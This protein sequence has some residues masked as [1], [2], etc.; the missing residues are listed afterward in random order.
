MKTQDVVMS[1]GTVL[2]CRVVPPYALGAVYKSVPEPKFP[3]IEEKSV[4][5]GS[6]EHPALP[7]TEQFRDY[8]R[9]IRQYRR[10][11]GERSLEFHL[12]YGIV[13]WMVPDAEEFA[14]E[15]P[16][17]WQ[18]DPMFVRYGGEEP[19][20]KNHKR[21]LYITLELITTQADAD[22]VDV[23]I[24]ATSLEEKSVTKEE[25][26]AAI[27]PFESEMGSSAQ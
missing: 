6:E 14:H 15:P 23:A 2:R 12:N 25:V 8:Q 19:R 21:F 22:K 27:S 20:D 9:K 1:D 17:D 11:I 16:K 10:E 5:G 18:P 7:G 3:K 26:E 4:A 13:G 24:G